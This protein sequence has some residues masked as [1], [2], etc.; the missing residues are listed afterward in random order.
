MGQWYDYEEKAK[1]SLII[2]MERSKRPM[3]VTAGKILDLSLVT[4]TTVIV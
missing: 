2:L 1:K 4:F 3:I